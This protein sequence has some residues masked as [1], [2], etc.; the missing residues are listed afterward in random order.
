MRLFENNKLYFRYIK[1]KLE[2]LIEK[3]SNYFIILNFK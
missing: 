2:I 3:D 1:K